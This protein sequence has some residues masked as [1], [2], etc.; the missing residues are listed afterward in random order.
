MLISDRHRFIFIHV[1]KTGGTSVRAA[2]KPYRDLPSM[3]TR[4]LARL[5]WCPHRRHASALEV[6]S[7]YPRRWRDYYTFAFVR[8][9]WAWQVSLY[10]F[11][12]Q[13]KGHHQGELARSFDSFHSYLEWRVH[14]DKHLQSQFL[15]D[16][17]GRLLVDY[18]G[19]IETMQD[20]FAT[21][22]TR[23]GIKAEL[24]HK[25]AS[26][27]HDYRTYYDAYTRRLVAEHF[28]EDIEHF[29][30]TFDGIA[31]ASGAAWSRPTS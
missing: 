14:E 27:H 26:S 23:L 8:N 30:Y 5:G 22:C 28:A 13:Q 25:N 21:L 24:P 1:Y 9:P 15:S 7:R 3:T 12:R 31:D 17:D 4:V 29:G 2:L 6:R 11:M 10:A 16:E 20:D 18:V 19:R